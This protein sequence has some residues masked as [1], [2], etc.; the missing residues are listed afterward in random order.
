MRPYVETHNLTTSLLTWRIELHTHVHLENGKTRWGDELTRM[1]LAN[2][3]CSIIAMQNWKKW[4]SM[5]IVTNT[6]TCNIVVK[7]QRFIFRAMLIQIKQDLTR[8]SFKR[9]LRGQQTNKP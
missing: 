5:R 2:A 3:L 8:L 9:Q 7:V 1:A 4:L 6:D